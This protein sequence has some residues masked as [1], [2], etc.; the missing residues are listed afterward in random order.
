MKVTFSTLFKRDLLDAESYYAAK[1]AQLGD[2]FHQR[3]K[4]TVRSIVK[5][6]GGDHFGPHGYRCR[7]CKP[8]PYLVYYQL[9]EDELY[10][11][12]LVHERRHP[13]YLRKGLE[14]TGG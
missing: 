6:K 12:G 2:E 14:E 11:L 10:V 7:K 3:V 13:D 5:W 4:E 8:F 1:S 9:E